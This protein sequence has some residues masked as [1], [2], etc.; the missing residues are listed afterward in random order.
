MDE[1]IYIKTN[2]RDLDRVLRAIKY[3]EKKREYA[4]KKAARD[5]E[6]DRGMPYSE[7]KERQLPS[8]QADIQTASS[9]VADY[10]E[11][12]GRK[13]V[14]ITNLASELTSGTHSDDDIKSVTTES[15]EYTLNPARPHL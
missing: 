6:M 15:T 7:D 1:A 5:S 11:R 10:L 13:A 14:K 8:I 12:E 9:I 4:R 3:Y 2:Y